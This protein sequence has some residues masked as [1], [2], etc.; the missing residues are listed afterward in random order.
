MIAVS[1]L[2]VV[3][4]GAGARAAWSVGSAAAVR[5]RLAERSPRRRVGPW[6]HAPR[7][8]VGWATRSGV[9]AEVIESAWPAAPVMASGLLIMSAALFNAPGL[10]LAIL[11]VVASP[12]V[13]FRW[14]A[15]EERRRRA[16]ALP[17]LLEDVARGLR[18][19]ASLRQ[20]LALSQDRVDDSL[21]AELGVVC[22][23]VAKGGSLEAALQTWSERQPVEGLRMAVAALTLGLDAGGAHGRA[24]DGVAESLRERLAV[25]REL[26]ALSSQARASAGVMAAAPVLFAGFTLSADPRTAHFLLGTPAGLVCLS[27]GLLL[28]CHRRVVDVA[29]HGGTCSSR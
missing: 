4:L 14:L 16:R 10:V 3:L 20:A 6:R 1:A 9:R 11:V 19:G 12:A 29:T 23:T 7:W 13:G 8:I 21:R 15:A 17:E 28:D 24:L 27:V 22:E 5:S 2:L 25:D 26:A 18:S